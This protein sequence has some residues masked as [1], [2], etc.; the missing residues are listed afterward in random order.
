MLGLLTAHE[1]K[2]AF[3]RRLLTIRMSTK[4]TPLQIRAQF[5]Y[6]SVIRYFNIIRARILK[7]GMSTGPSRVIEN[8]SFKPRHYLDNFYQTKRLSRRDSE[9]PIK[10]LYPRKSLSSYLLTL[11]PVFPR[12]LLAY[13]VNVFLGWGL[14][15]VSFSLVSKQR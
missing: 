6:I 12:L 13:C 14:C 5:Q 3:S 9:S 2:R 4:T 10:A 11:F 15:F 1:D 7:V 8:I